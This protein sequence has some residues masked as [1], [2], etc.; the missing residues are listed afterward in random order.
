M[1]GR[2]IKG[3]SVRKRREVGVCDEDWETL[4]AAVADGP[5]KSINDWLAR[6][7]AMYRLV[8]LALEQLRHRAAS[9][10]EDDGGQGG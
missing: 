1:T 2:P 10:K 8:P 6:M 4:K 9:N 7:A 3:L 5:D